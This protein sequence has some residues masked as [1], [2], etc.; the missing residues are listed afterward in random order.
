MRPVINVKNPDKIDELFCN[1]L[2]ILVLISLQYKV[3]AKYYQY[4]AQYES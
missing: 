3:Y 1:L 4:A 2:L